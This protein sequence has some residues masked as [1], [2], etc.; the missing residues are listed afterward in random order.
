MNKNDFRRFLSSVGTVLVLLSVSG[1]QI[2]YN[3]MNLFSDDVISSYEPE[4]DLKSVSKAYKDTFFSTL[5]IV[6][7]TPYNKTYLAD[8]FQAFHVDLDYNSCYF[9]LNEYITIYNFINI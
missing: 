6:R 1:C 9:F 4:F 3:V 7:K 2:D 5:P 8:L